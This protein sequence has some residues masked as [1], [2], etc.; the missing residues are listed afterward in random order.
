MSVPV[1][2]ALTQRHVR[3]SRAER[4]CPV[5]GVLR[6]HSTAVQAPL[7]ISMPHG[8]GPEVVR[9]SDG[10]EMHSWFDEHGDLHRDDGPACILKYPDGSVREES[11]IQHGAGHRVDGPQFLLYN[12]DGTIV[13]EIWRIDGQSHR[14]DGPARIFR[15]DD[16]TIKEE[17]WFLRGERVKRHAV[18]REFLMHEGVAVSEAAAE[19][20]D[21]P[22]EQWGEISLD[23]IALARQFHDDFADPQ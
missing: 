22:H 13:E 17:G 4:E 9:E 1:C 3:G 16:G 7:P 20:L 8:G 11:W 23:E 15:F 6:D 10:S 19:M 14:I 18:L 2:T 12:P 5:H 21:R